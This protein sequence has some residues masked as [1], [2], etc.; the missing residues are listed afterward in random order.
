M[1][2]SSTLALSQ[3]LAMFHLPDKNLTLS[4]AIP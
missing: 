1:R 4:L 3:K 2:L